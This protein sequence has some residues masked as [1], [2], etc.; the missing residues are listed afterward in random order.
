MED[1]DLLEDRVGGSAVAPECFH[2]RVVVGI[3]DA[4]HRE[5]ETSASNA[6]AKRPEMSVEVP[7]PFLGV[8]TRKIKRRAAMSRTPPKFRTTKL[9][10]TGS[11]F[12]L[13]C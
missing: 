4:A 7:S 8:G 10:S 5:C 9:P 3:F 11:E 2:H 13:L 1:F 6:V 12:P